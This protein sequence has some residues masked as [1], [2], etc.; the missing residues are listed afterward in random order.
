MENHPIPQDVTGFKFKL[1]GSI[2]VKQFLYIVGGGILAAICY[3][4]PFSPFIKIP[5]AI[6]FGGMG[7]AIAFI[8]VDGRPMDVMLKNFLR[9]LPAENQY[10]FKKRG[11]DALIIDFF[12]PITAVA[13][14]DEKVKTDADKAQD[15]RRALLYKTL[16][17]SY[18]PDA[19]EQEVLTNINTYLNESSHSATPPQQNIDAM[20]AESAPVQIATPP[21]ALSMNNMD[22]LKVVTPPKV[23]V[24][25]TILPRPAPVIQEIEK[26]EPI[27]APQPLPVA[28]VA[29]VQPEPVAPRVTQTPVEP[30]ATIATPLQQ[31][32][33]AQPTPSIAPDESKNVTSVL[34]EASLQAGFPE[35]P[36]TPNIV[37]GI[38]RDPRGKVIPNILVEIM[39]VQGIPVRAFKTNALGQ[40][41][42]ATPLPNGEYN[43]L[44]EDPRKLNEFEQIHIS[45][46]GDI[47]N[48]IE[49]IS[50]DQRER[51]RRELF[52]Q[53]TQAIQQPAATA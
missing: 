49:I 3:I 20:P 23:R 44:L 6:L 39:S 17:Q 10:I 8:P 53:N 16:K 14:R 21:T 46:T 45:L 7:A 34:P 52:G 37:M 24:I 12:T 38:I 40:F 48:P 43:V 32:V 50:T 29:P 18:K 42:A 22:S 4:L 28:Q 35:L 27:P 25:E 19:K 1:I 31:A 2:T 33:I 51:L 15:D 30:I 41:A 26:P 36:D 13:V 47:F 11:A 9:A 5:F